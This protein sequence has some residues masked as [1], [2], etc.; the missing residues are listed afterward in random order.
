VPAGWVAVVRPDRVVM[1]DG[2][3]AAAQQL[4]RQSLA[5]LHAA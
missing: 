4:A 3:L 1:A 2:P 5:L